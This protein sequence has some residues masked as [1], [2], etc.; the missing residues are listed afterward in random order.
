MITTTLKP[1]VWER[2]LAAHPD[3]EFA[4]YV[5]TGIRHGFRIGFDYHRARLI[6]VHR[7]MKSAMEHGEVVERYLGEEREAQRVLGPFKRSLFPEVHVSP[8]GVIPKADP[9]KW[10]LIL[11]LSSP[12]GN[13]VNDG[14]AKELC[15]LSYVTVDDIATRVLKLGKGALVAKFDLKAAYRHIPVHPDD[16]RLLGMEWKGGLYLDAALPFGLRSAPVIFNAVAEA[17]AFTIRQRGVDG[18]DHYLDDFILVENPRSQQCKRNLEVA[19]ATCEEVGFRVAPGKTEG[20][21]TSL[22]LLGVELDTELMELRL[23]QKKLFKLRE[24]VEKWR[25]RKACTKRELQSLAGYL[26]HACKVIRPGRRFLRGVFGLLSRFER[27][28]HMIRLNAAFRADMEW[29]HVFAEKWNGVSMLRNVAYQSPSVEIWSDASGSWG[30][31]AFWGPQWFQVQWSGWPGFTGASIAAKELLPIIVA[32]AIWGPS[33]RG[34]TVLCHCD[35]EAVVAAVKSGYCRDPT[36]AHM[37]RCLLFLETKYDASL[38]AIHVPGIE[39]GAA[40]S[41]SRNNLPQFFDLLLQA[42]QN[43]CKVPDNLVS[44]LIR[45]RPWTSDDWKSWLGTLLTTR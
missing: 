15:S 1:D 2:A 18:M 6:P 14:I 37:L 17:L 29:W 38:S 26:N 21:T 24:L 9:G 23:P 39:N 10:R 34:A 43:P 35:N 7:N 8:F 40:D 4:Q 30:C 22:S 36:L 13:S 20:P 25:R 42:H 44:H 16:R 27:I 19:L 31:G 3:R 41:I 12:R 11:D 32:T 45:D 28:D 5:C 33:W